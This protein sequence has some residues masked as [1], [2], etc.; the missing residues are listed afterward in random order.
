VPIARPAFTGAPRL[1]VRLPPFGRAD[2]ARALV[3]V[4]VPILLLAVLT[5]EGVSVVLPIIEALV[6]VVAVLVVRRHPGPALCVLVVFLPIQEVLLAFLLRVG[7]PAGVIRGLGGV[8]ETIVIGLAI[9]AISRP[10]TER[11][12]LDALDRLVI[13]YLLLLT[14]YIFLPL[15]LTGLFEAVPT[16]AR[17]LAVRDDGLFALAF[18]GARHVAIAEAARQRVFQ[19]VVATMSL[20]AASALFE[21]VDSKEWNNLLSKDLHIQAYQ[22]LITGV[23]APANDALT[24]GSI[25][26]HAIVRVS[27]LLLSPLTIGFALLVPLAYALQRLTTTRLRATGGLVAAL[28]LAAILVT[29]TRS[30]ILAGVLTVLL[31]VRF[32]FRRLSPGRFRV[33]V[34]LG[35]ASVVLAPLAGSSAPVQRL[36]TTFNGSDPS[37]QDHR[38]SLEIGLT[39]VRENPLGR[40]LGTAPAIGDRYDVAGRVISENAYLQVANEVGIE[41]M[42]V[43]VLMLGCLLRELQRS[44]RGDGRNAERATALLAAG[45]GISLG[46]FFLHVWADFPT[47]VTFWALAGMTVGRTAPDGRL[48]DAETA[49]RLADGAFR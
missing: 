24:H 42:I 16:S 15:I 5:V 10:R 1:S 28:C 13:T 11:R 21:Y 27:G 49:G 2:A 46:G 32:S 36:A 47:A 19:A 17:L 48:P 12:R 31:V 18:L 23:S 34:V 7:T 40:G 38:N 45:L 14:A 35:L 30:A 37:T 4:L 26:G 6:A 39:V 22:L 29:L 43:F 9:A 20:V 41:T 33:L 25:D 8:K 3:T 44:S